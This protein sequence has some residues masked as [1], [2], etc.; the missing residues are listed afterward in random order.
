MYKSLKIHGKHQGTGKFSTGGTKRSKAAAG[1]HI[2]AGSVQKSNKP[3]LSVVSDSEVSKN[4]YVFEDQMPIRKEGGDVICIEN[5]KAG[6]FALV[7]TTG[8]GREHQ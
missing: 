7:S 5:P 1:T 6:C 2:V 3:I 8:W 4:P